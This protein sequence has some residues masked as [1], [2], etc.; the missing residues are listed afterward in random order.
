MSTNPSEIFVDPRIRILKAVQNNEQDTVE[1]LLRSNP[2]LI[3]AKTTTKGSSLLHIAA[4]RG[5]ANICGLLNHYKHETNPVDNEGQTPYQRAQSPEVKS[6]LVDQH[7]DYLS[8]TFYTSLQI[9]TPNKPF[10]NSIE[11]KIIV[12][13]K[14]EFSRLPMNP[15]GSSAFGFT[16]FRPAPDARSN[17]DFALLTIFRQ[18]ILMTPYY[19]EL[20]V[21][22]ENEQAIQFIEELS[23]TQQGLYGPVTPIPIDEFTRF[24]TRS[25]LK[26]ISSALALYPFLKEYPQED[27]KQDI[28]EAKKM[29]LAFGL[30]GLVDYFNKCTP[31]QMHYLQTKMKC[32][33]S[34]IQHVNKIICTENVVK[35]L[36]IADEMNSKYTREEAVE[37]SASPTTSA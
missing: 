20:L 17:R 7:M 9:P 24:E 1:H 34:V 22:H 29:F 28:T 32:F 19:G 11:R 27:D 26:F 25:Y 4:E 31:K 5:Y 16:Q 12:L 3:N 33:D 35:N 2:S 18:D 37:A 13:D 6:L 30:V 15:L 14:I 23:N 21:I 8:H 36:A 10:I